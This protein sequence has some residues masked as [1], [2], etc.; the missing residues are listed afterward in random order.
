MG[1]YALSSQQN[2]CQTLTLTAEAGV[3][4]Q[5]WL[6]QTN[7]INCQEIWHNSSTVRVAYSNTSD[8]SFGGFM[9]EHGSCCPRGMVSG[10]ENQELH[11]ERA[12]G[13]EDGT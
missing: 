3:E 13:C 11:L 6:D 9:V 7:N 8:V 2:W 5:F 12:A 4:L 1:M 10:G